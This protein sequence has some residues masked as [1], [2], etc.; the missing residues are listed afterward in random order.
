MKAMMGKL[1]E[2]VLCVSVAS[3]PSERTTGALTNALG[4]QEATGELWQE[5][6]QYSVRKASPIP[7]GCSKNLL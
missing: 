5:Q 1:Q 4:Q 6:S 2:I 3:W 7:V